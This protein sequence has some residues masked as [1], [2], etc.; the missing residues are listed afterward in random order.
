M[1]KQ[2]GIILLVAGICLLIWGFNLYGAFSS[3]VARVFTGAPTDKTMTIL[4]AG[5][6]CTALGIFQLARKSK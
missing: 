1:N 4:I 5:G 2:I 6:V 3:R